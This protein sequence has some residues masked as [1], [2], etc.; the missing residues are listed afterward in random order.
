[1][2]KL[3]CLMGKSSS[4]KD[5]LYRLLLQDTTLH[6]QRIVPYTTRPIRSG[7]TEGKEY[8]FTN[9]ASFA[10]LKNAGKV[11]EARCYQTYHGDW[12]YFTVDDGQIDFS[13]QDYLIIGTPESYNKTREYFGEENVVPLYIEL[14]DGERLNRA[15]CRER[16]QAEPKYE[17][18]CR[19]FLADSVDFSEEKLQQA[20][21]ERRFYNQDLQECLEEILAYIK[22]QKEGKQNGSSED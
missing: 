22:E 6:L 15:L 17:E 4:G 1:M 19:R 20:G 9:E 12:Y 21:I 16:N 11:I 8:H 7:E 3:F 10:A 13:G 18:M 14:E 2:G 5:T